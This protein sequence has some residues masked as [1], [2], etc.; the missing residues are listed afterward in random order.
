[1]IAGKLGGRRIAEGSWAHEGFREFYGFGRGRKCWVGER[2]APN[3]VMYRACAS[4]IAIAIGV[5]VC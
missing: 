5:P 1:M 3:V 4:Q 2:G